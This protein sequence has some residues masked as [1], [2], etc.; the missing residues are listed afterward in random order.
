MHQISQRISFR[1]TWLVFLALL[2]I[3]YGCS[4]AP[5]KKGISDANVE[6]STTQEIAKGDDWYVVNPHVGAEIQMNGC[7]GYEFGSSVNKVLAQIKK[8]RMFAKL[9]VEQKKYDDGVHSVKLNGYYFK[10]AAIRDEDLSF[11]TWFWFYQDKLYTVEILFHSPFSDVVRKKADDFW[12]QT[13]KNNAPEVCREESTQ[14]I[15]RFGKGSGYSK[16]RLRLTFDEEAKD[17]LGSYACQRPSLF[18]PKL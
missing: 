13:L 18:A 5:E 4:S 1:S 2:L 9:K 10:Q 7:N 14:F 15:C 11:Y 17:N 8:N 16:I 12:T 6:T 3:P